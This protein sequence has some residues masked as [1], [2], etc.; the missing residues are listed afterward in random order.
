MSPKAANSIDAYVAGR[1]RTHRRQIGLSQADVAKKLGV[2]F[3]Q[4]QKYEAGINRVGAG[5][6]F[7]LA[8][9]YGIPVQ[10]FFPRGHVSP[11]A[12]KR[13]AKTDEIAAFAASAEGFRLCEA[14]L[15]IKD[16]KQR[17]VI[18]SLIEEMTEQ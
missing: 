9:L 13:T 15:R 8:S 16:G 7:Q 12:G 17:R 4:I 5:R 18:I 11:D 1:L 6:L 14:F 3:Q 10:E 2:T